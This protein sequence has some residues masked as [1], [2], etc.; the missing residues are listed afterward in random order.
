MRL[1]IGKMP[2]M[3]RPPSTD[4]HDEDPRGQ[5][6]E[7]LRGRPSI[8][9]SGTA[10]GSPATAAQLSRLAR[11]L[12]QQLDSPATLQHAVHWAVQLIPGAQH[13]SISLV[14]RRRQITSAAA[15]DEL[16]RRFD[17]LQQQLGQG[18]CLE[19]MYE[20]HTVRVHDL[21]GEARWP[22]L[23]Q[24]WAQVGVRSALCLQLFVHGQDLGALNV[25]STRTGAFGDEAE[26]V[27]LLVASHAALALAAVLQVEGLN[28]ANVTRA[29]IG[30]A[31]GIL[32]E[33]FKISAQVA[34]ALLA[35]I[36]QDSNRKLRLVAE[37][38]VR[39]GQVPA[40]PTGRARQDSY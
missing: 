11:Q 2:S 36:S 25:L 30:Q 22:V 35:R 21:A 28:Q 16:P 37:D 8:H 4:Q 40:P 38:L 1:L 14:R 17:D 29:V 7:D 19:A 9:D 27:G 15:T 24:R 6:G 5:P 26:H 18:P 32:M 13:A 39:T 10:T 12:Q 34:F 3:Q 23:A 20:Q 33:R 31:E